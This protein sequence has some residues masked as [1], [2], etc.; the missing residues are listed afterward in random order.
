[1]GPNDHPWTS[2]WPDQPGGQFWSAPA[3]LGARLLHRRP[4][5]SSKQAKA[6]S[7]PACKR[8]PPR[9]NVVGQDNDLSGGGKHAVRRKNFHV[10]RHT[11]RVLEAG[12]RRGW[13]CGSG[14]GGFV[15]VCIYRSC[16]G[17]DAKDPP[18]EPFRATV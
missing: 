18:V 9:C 3:D 17:Q 4:P 16:T 14:A 13:S 12:G 6:F 15:A 11:T 5:Q 2:W 10:S 7:A 1:C 8:A